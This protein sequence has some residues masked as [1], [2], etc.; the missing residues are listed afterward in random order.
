MP[1]L[2]E[3]QTT[4]SQLNKV[5]PGLSVTSVWTDWEKMLRGESFAAFKK[6]IIGRKVLRAHRRAKNVLIELDGGKTL[7]VH[8]KMTGH[9][10]YGKFKLKK[11]RWAPDEEGPLNDPYNRFIHFVFSLSNGKH[12]AFSDVRKFGKIALLDTALLDTSPHLALLGPEPLQ[13]NFTLAKFKERLRARPSGRIKQVLMDQTVIAGIGNIYSDEMLFLA[14]IHPE[15]RVSILRDS[16]F[17]TLY[18]AMR[19]VL[20]NGID[21]GGDSTSDYRNIYGESGAFH[22]RHR[23]YRRTGKPCVIRAC[24]GT[25]LRKKVGGR[26]AH[27]CGIHQKMRKQ[28]DGR[29]S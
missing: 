27:Y 13:R 23:A 16:D 5:L 4:S 28:K 29:R 12:L 1:E 3:V 17:K 6:E 21:F 26:S 9:L 19:R 7:L 10:L 20:L 15:E 22:E 24:K 25:I 11:G 14:S 8:M 18:N 2:P